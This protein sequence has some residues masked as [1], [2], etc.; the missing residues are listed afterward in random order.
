LLANF[1]VFDEIFVERKISIDVFLPISFIVMLI[2][3][4]FRIIRTD[5]RRDIIEN[6]LC[7]IHSCE[8]TW[9]IVTLVHYRATI[10]SQI[11]YNSQPFKN[12]NWYNVDKIYL[13]NIGSE[14]ERIINN[15]FC[16]DNWINERTKN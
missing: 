5:R 11:S 16:L 7:S 2:F 15:L 13:K 4:I 12:K 3:T 6:E 8:I 1:V 9:Q 10:Q 14:S